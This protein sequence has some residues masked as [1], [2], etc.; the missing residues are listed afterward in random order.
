MTP[1]AGNLQSSRMSFMAERNRLPRSGSRLLRRRHAIS[2]P[3]KKDYR[4]GKSRRTPHTPRWR[5]CS[6]K[7]S[8]ARIDNAKIV[9]VGFCH[10]QV[11]KLAPSTTNKFL[12]S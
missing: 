3:E 7:Y 9:I 2:C 6:A 4:K 1:L 5:I 11:T 10:P 12:M 8:E